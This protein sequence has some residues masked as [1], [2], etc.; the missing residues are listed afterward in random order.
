MDV[1]Y[2]NNSSLFI[3]FINK[4]KDFINVDNI[5]KSNISIQIETFL[6]IIFHISKHL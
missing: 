2:C 4:N 6:Y 5:N 1:K 3:D